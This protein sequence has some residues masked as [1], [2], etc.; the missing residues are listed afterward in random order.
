M[1]SS[2]FVCGPIRCTKTVVAHDTTCRKQCPPHQC[3]WYTSY[4]HLKVTTKL[5]HPYFWDDPALDTARLTRQSTKKLRPIV[6][7]Q[8]NIGKERYNQ[9]FGKV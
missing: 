3:R 1:R 4:V 8:Y 2:C 7:V 5:N 9:L 6:L